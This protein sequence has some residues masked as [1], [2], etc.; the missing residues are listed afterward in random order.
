MISVIAYGMFLKLRTVIHFLWLKHTPNQATL[1]ELKEA[2]AKSMI[3][4]RALEK[5]IAAFDGWGTKFIDL[6]RSG[7]HHDTRKVHLVRA[8]IEGEGCISQKKIV[9][10]LGIHNKHIRCILH[11]GLNIG[12]AN[13]RWMPHALNSS[14]KTVRVQV[15][16]GYLISWKATEAEVC[17]LCTL[18]M[19]CECT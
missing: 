11:N 14:Q 8:Q 9:Q 10:L 6:P 19:K 15:S 4:R 16:G 5:W 1:S 7:G 18:G 2:S 3:S 12:K 13:F 17:Q